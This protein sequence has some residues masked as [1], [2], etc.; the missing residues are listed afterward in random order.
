MNTPQTVP[1]TGKPFLLLWLGAGVVVLLILGLA[2]SMVRSSGGV[3]HMTV[4]KSPS[5]ECCTAWVE[6]L[7]K[8]GFSVTV[9][10]QED[11]NAVKKRLGVPEGMTSCHTGVIGDYVVEGHVP[12]EDLRRLLQERPAVHGLAVPGMPIGSPGMEVPGQKPD[13]YAVLTF[14]RDGTT[15]VFANH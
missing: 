8:N 7:L 1:P 15:R 10:K 13:P 2:W 3:S 12:A 14:T 11:M 5:C 4:Y 9:E 6:H